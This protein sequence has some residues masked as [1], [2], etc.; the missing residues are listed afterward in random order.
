MSKPDDNK[1][2]NFLVRCWQW[3]GFS[4][5][6]LWDWLVLLIVPLVLGFGVYYFQQQASKRQQQSAIDKARQDS[7]ANYLSQMVTLMVDKHLLDPPDNLADTE[8]STRDAAIIAARSL[9]GSVLKTLDAKRNAQILRFLSDAKLITVI[10]EA[11]V[12]QDID[13]Q[14]VDLGGLQLDEIDLSGADLSNVTLAG[15]S[16][17]R[18]IL[19]KTNLS[20][21][22]L[23]FTGMSGAKLIGTNFQNAVALETAFLDNVEIEEQSSSCAAYTDRYRDED[24]R[25]IFPKG[26]LLNPPPSDSAR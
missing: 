9:T 8:K 15:A 17:E 24:C 18:A 22:F 10:S 23:Y 2:E 14:G 26:F 19:L 4:D 7:L 20:G 25:T 6:R 5:K 12:F 16:L 21:A 13:L 3:T 1:K 11:G